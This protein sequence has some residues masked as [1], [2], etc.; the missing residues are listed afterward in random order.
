M[1][2]RMSD[3][4]TARKWLG[5]CI[6]LALIS[7]FFSAHALTACALLLLDDIPPGTIRSIEPYYKNDLLLRVDNGRRQVLWGGGVSYKGGQ[8]VVPHAGDHIEK[9][10]SWIYWINGRP[11]S[12]P[13][14]IS[15][16]SGPA[17]IFIVIYLLVAGAFVV[18]FRR[19]PLGF[20]RYRNSVITVRPLRYL[21]TAAATMILSWGV[22]V[23]LA[24]IGLAV[25]AGCFRT[26]IGLGFG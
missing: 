5:A 6:L 1:N 4:E 10:G 25:I 3:D 11:I 22:L 23:V 2:R 13:S 18:R 15:R 7:V 24:A 20:F 12:D 14:L 21:P 9:R 26:M 16:N 19:N 17:P 8:L